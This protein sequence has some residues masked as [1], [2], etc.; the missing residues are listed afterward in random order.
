MQIR[1]DYLTRLGGD[2][3][4]ATKTSEYLKKLRVHVDLS[5]NPQ[6][7]LSD[8]DI[9]HL[10]NVTRVDETFEY[11]KNAVT[12]QKPVVFS[13]IYWNSEE[14]EANLSVF[15]K[16]PTCTGRIRNLSQAKDNL[17]HLKKHSTLALSDILL[18]NS[19]SERDLL[20][21]D[22]GLGD[23]DFL[24]VPNA[25]DLSFEH[26][27]REQ[28]VRTHGI[29][30]FVLCAARIELRKNQLSL[31][32]AVADLKI[33]LVLIGDCF[34]PEYL[35]ACKGAADANVRF[36]PSLSQIDLASAYKAA[37]VHVLASWFETPGL[38]SL[39]AALAGCNIVSTDRGSAKEYFGESAWY[40][41]P[42]DINSIRLAVSSAF[43]AEKTA[44]LKEHVRRNFTWESAAEMTLQA[45][46]RVLDGKAQRRSSEALSRLMSYVIESEA[47]VE[48]FELYSYDLAQFK[49]K[50]TLASLRQMVRR[51][52]R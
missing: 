43:R 19:A 45:Y 52:L 18:P 30:D 11:L 27:S 28:F 16:R 29:S 39:E 10:F 46:K 22:F 37:R 6:E 13:T 20:V 41:D 35:G 17:K 49:N 38:A 42:T 7:D 44:E 12:Q 26:A 2:A 14:Y 36:I 21:R 23:K 9:V 32:R 24:I 8:Y 25:V 34:E 15:L 48:Q 50:I 4:Q 51:L 40:C 47:L 3:I 31:I 5:T 33:P 1:P